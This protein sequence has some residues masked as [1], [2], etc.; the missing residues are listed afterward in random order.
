MCDAVDFED[1]EAEDGGEDAQREACEEFGRPAV[2]VREL[3]D[4][5]QSPDAVEEEDYLHDG[6]AHDAP[7]FFAE[8]R[9][10]AGEFAPECPRFE[11]RFEEEDA[12]YD[13]CDDDGE[14]QEDC[15]EGVGFWDRE[16]FDVA[17]DAVHESLVGRLLVC[18]VAGCAAV[19]RGLDVAGEYEETSLRYA[20]CRLSCGVVGIDEGC[21]FEELIVHVCQIAAGVL[22]EGVDRRLESG[23]WNEPG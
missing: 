3:E 22:S 9:E 5:I 8:C 16:L 19:D 7:V 14:D 17:L 15:H 12:Y 21:V 4:A 2:A 18:C 13:G 23:P 1:V 20:A 11:D 10:R 6:L